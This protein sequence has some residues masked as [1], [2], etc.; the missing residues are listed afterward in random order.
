MGD[1]RE[2]PFLEVITCSGKTALRE[3]E[4]LCAIR[5]PKLENEYHWRFTKVGRR[6]AMSIS[7]LTVSTLARFTDERRLRDLRVSIGAVFQK[8]MR[9]FELEQGSLG[10]ALTDET[11]E[12]IAF[13]F[14]ERLPQI[15]GRRASTKYK[16][17]VSQMILARM[18]REMRDEQ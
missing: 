14:S 10:R 8:P 18:L 13:A 1:I 4:I 2:L 16:Q 15:A 11:I 6:N 3:K 17:P 12:E 7:R 9:F 5:I